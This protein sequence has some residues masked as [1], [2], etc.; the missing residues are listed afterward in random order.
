MASNER[1]KK[2]TAKRKGEQSERKVKNAFTGNLTKIR[3]KEGYD[4][5][6]RKEQKKASTEEKNV[7]YHAEL[8]CKKFAGFGFVCFIKKR[9][10]ADDLAALK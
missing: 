7:I 3:E 10:T 5:K 2:E 4:H 8:F 1:K 6:S 9:K